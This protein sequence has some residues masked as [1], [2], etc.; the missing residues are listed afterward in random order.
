MLYQI[1]TYIKDEDRIFTPN[2]PWCCKGWKA[3]PLFPHFRAFHFHCKITNKYDT[4]YLRKFRMCMLSATLCWI[5]SQNGNLISFG[6]WGGF[7]ISYSQYILKCK[8]EKLCTQIT[9]DID[10]Q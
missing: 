6:G 1:F 8:N 3:L 5:L 2:K 7:S 9:R 10:R 4:E